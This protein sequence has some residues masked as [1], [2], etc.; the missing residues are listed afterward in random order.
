M[1]IKVFL[2]ILF[3]FSV[4]TFGQTNEKPNAYKVD[5]FSDI[6]DSALTQKTS[7]YAKKILE[8]PKSYGFIYTYGEEKY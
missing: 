1:F 8:I 4:S 3:A 6:K 7:D 2:I 5:E